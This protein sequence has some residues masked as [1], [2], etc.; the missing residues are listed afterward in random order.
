MISQGIEN[1]NAI[2]EACQ[3]TLAGLDSADPESKEVLQ[4]VIEILEDLKTKFFLKTNLAIP[5]TNASRKDATELQSL[6]E[7]HDLSCFSEVLARFQGNM[8][9]L[10]KEANMD[11]LII[12]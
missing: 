5:I 7:K 4:S 12:T 11:G 2:I 1:V 8:E 9:K 6:V 3:L 10:L